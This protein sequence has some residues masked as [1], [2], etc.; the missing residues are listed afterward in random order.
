M[1]WQ[2]IVSYSAIVTVGNAG[3]GNCPVPWC[4]HNGV[5][6]LRA[7][8]LTLCVGC[9]MAACPW[10][11]GHPGPDPGGSEPPLGE[12]TAGATRCRPAELDP[13]PACGCCGGRCPHLLC[14]NIRATSWHLQSDIIV[15]PEQQHSNNRATSSQPLNN[16]VAT[17]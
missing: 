3:L 14:S 11:L 15:T 10:R 12:A 4:S 1:P 9:T 16:N 5:L 17:T 2:P 6:H 13:L 7:S 8:I